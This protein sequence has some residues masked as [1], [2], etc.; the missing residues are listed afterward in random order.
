MCVTSS[1]NDATQYLP[2]GAALSIDERCSPAKSS[3]SGIETFNL[4]RLSQAYTIV[5]HGV[6]HSACRN[7]PL[8]IIIPKSSV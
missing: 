6:D 7:H 5:P 8:K 1:I 3:P 4:A 2:T